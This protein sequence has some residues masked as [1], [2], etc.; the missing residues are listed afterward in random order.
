MSN[1]SILDRLGVDI[2]YQ[3]THTKTIT[4]DDI[5]RFAEI[6]GDFSPVHI[7]PAY[8]RK[9]FFQ[10]RI[11]HGLMAVLLLSAAIA[12]L[13]GMVV[14]LSNSS[15]FRKPVKIGDTITATA[16]VSTVRKGMGIVVLKSNCTNQNGELV[17]EA[18]T[19]VRI[20]EPPA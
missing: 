14:L 10:G 20:Y 1:N 6:S 18:E 8:A 9:T 3:T 19:M 5:A 15:K 4:G 13:P 12:K 11:A 17:A 7:S 16:T 2:G